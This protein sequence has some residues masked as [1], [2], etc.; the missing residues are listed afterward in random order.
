M[1][2]LLVIT[3]LS[4]SALAENG[5]FEEGGGFHVALMSLAALFGLVTVATGARNSRIKS[6]RNLMPQEIPRRLHRYSAVTYYSL[7]LGTFVL[8][9]NSFY[10][11]QGRLFFTLHGQMGLLAVSFAL[12]GIA[13]GLVKLWKPPVL[14]RV[15][16]FFN[17]TAIL[18]LFATIMLG[19]ALGD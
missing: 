15:H 5:E 2:A 19:L 17:A 18:L 16:I 10:A 6:I 14:W 8:W 4:G 9:T 12:V 1:I 11:T 13:T 7:F 3:V